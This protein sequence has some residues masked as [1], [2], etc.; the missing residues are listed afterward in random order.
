MLS[1][2]KGLAAALLLV[3]S[4]GAPAGAA[5]VNYARFYTG[6]TT[7]TGP[8]SGAGTVYD[9]TKGLSTNC[10]TSGSCS[11]DNLAYSQ[12]YTG[13]PTLT[14]TAGGTNKVW[15]D[16]S[17]NYA[18]LGVGLTSQGGEAD[19]IAGSDILKLT[20]SSNVKLIGV[21]TLFSSAHTPFGEG[22][23]FQTVASIN[24]AVNTIKFKLSLDLGVHWLTV[25]FADANLMLLDYES[26]T[27]W[28][29]EKDYNPSFYVSALAFESCGPAGS[30]CTP[31][32]GTP[33]PGALPLF[34][35]GI[36][37]L[38]ALG[39]RRKRKNAAARAA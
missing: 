20:F 7:Y 38:G 25:T 36:G 17:P 23:S 37:A 26:T 28:F 39:W 5:T 12:T 24:S 13:L 2:K 22:S 30:S 4:F 35:T 29:K 34:A 32:P 9:A 27:F 19:Q 3:C 1:S 16:L 14:A 11:S 15:D 18:G 33:L 21:G 10:P 8:Y 31:P 6:G